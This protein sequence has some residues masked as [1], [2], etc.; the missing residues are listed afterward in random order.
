VPRRRLVVVLLVATACG[1]SSH[2]APRPPPGPATLHLQPTQARFAVQV[3]AGALTGRATAELEVRAAERG[4]L[5]AVLTLSGTG[6]PARAALGDPVA[7]LDSVRFRWRMGATGQIVAAGGPAAPSRVPETTLRRALDLWPLVSAVVPR[8]PEGPVVE[9]ARWDAYQ[10]T[11]VIGGGQER[12][13]VITGEWRL[14]KILTQAPMMAVLE[15]DLTIVVRDP[16][17]PSDQQ[18][19]HARTITARAAVYVNLV[20]GAVDFATV[21]S[22]A[23]SWQARRL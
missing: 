5:L 6:T 19:A 3:D 15:S 13:V 20:R 18:Q 21:S 14:A 9:G 11:E 7:G 4:E 23:F 22:E 10:R 8:L 1:G 2:P 16:A 12:V 17:L